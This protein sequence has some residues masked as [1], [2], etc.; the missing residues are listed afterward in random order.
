MAVKVGM[1]VRVR[2]RSAQRGTTLLEMAIA[3]LILSLVLILVAEALFDVQ[4]HVVR[5]GE[6]VLDPI[7]GPAVQRLTA[8]IGASTDAVASGSSLVL[9]GHPAGAI[10][11]ELRDQTLWRVG[12]GADGRSDQREVLGDVLCWRARVEGGGSGDRPLVRIDLCYQ[13]TGRLGPQTSGARAF[14]PPSAA[15]ERSFVV[16][17]RGA[18][19]DGW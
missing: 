6:Q 5:T 4:R 3:S 7:V 12:V 19:G 18:R 11:Y 17:V 10:T 15:R 1:A 13:E 14:R 8:E 16:A 2:N 9:V